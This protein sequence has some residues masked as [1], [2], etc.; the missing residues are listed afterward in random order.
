MI[1]IAIQLAN[2]SPEQA[3]SGQGS[4]SLQSLQ[5]NDLRLLPVFI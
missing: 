5:G 2:F 3:L 1:H 4:L